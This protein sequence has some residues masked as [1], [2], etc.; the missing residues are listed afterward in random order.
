MQAQM[1]EQELQRVSQH[2]RALEE[3]LAQTEQF[4]EQLK[5]LPNAKNKALLAPLGRGVFANTEIKDSNVIV[6]VGAGIAVERSLNE[7]TE[8]MGRN[9]VQIK[10]ALMQLQTQ[11]DFYIGQMQALL[12]QA[13]NMQKK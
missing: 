13:Q 10:Q 4:N 9:V 6:Q 11:E 1:L 5:E 7:V 12:E 2:K 3:E 8:L